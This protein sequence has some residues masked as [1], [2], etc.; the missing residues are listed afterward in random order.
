MPR[1]HGLVHYTLMVT[2]A[3]LVSAAI[4]VSYYTWQAVATPFP[5]LDIRAEGSF[6]LTEDPELGFAARANTATHWVDRRAGFAFDIFTDRRRARVNRAGDQSP[7]RV[8]LVT[9]GGSFAFG[10]GVANEETFSYL[11]GEHVR[12]LTTANLAFSSYGTVQAL[13]RLRQNTDLDP[14]YVVYAVINDHLRRNLSPCAPNITPDC[15]PVAHVVFDA[16]GEPS[17]APPPA[18]HVLPPGT[19]ERFLRDVVF[20][21]DVGIAD[22]LWKARFDLFRITRD[23]AFAYEDT[24]EYRRKAVAFLL[25][26]MAAES[27]AMGARLLVAFVPQLTGPDGSLATPAPELMEAVAGKPLSFLD[28]T[29]YFARAMMRPDAPPLF[30]PD[31]GHPSVAGHRV[32]AQAIEEAWLNP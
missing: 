26:A 9:V 32:I 29:P 5:K 28:L 12:G 8:D 14:R 23:N 6:A 3:V 20:R 22:V 21:D 11:L 2:L 17:L 27:K 30:I 25:D 31:D 4:P 1:R 24:P 10:H 16:V 18:E 13:Q 19:R 7:E 15:L